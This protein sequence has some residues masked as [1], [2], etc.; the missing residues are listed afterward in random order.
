[1]EKMVRNRKKIGQ[2]IKRNSL[3]AAFAEKIFRKTMK[4]Q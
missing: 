3:F 2:M 1:M 4:I